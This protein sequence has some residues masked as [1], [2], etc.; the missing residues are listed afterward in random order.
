MSLGRVLVVEKLDGVCG[1]VEGSVWTR[2]HAVSGEVGHH[3][4]LKAVRR[5]SNWP[6]II[7]RKRL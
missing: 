5:G 7:V 4:D 3:S 6:L 1:E 2:L